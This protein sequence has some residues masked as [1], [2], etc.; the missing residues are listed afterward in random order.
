MMGVTVA[1]LALAACSSDGGADVEISMAMAPP[2]GTF[3]ASGDAVDD[4]MLCAT[5]QW[6]DG[7]TFDEDGDPISGEEWAQAFDSAMA[8]ETVVSGISVRT[9]TC[10]D[11][12]AVGSI[13]VADTVSIDFAQIDPQEWSEGDIASAEAGTWSVDG[14]TGDMSGMTGG[15]DLTWNLDGQQIVY[16]GQVSES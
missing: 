10:T 14:A 11:E 16:S 2:P 5:G 8:D 9:F 15:G 7:G 6:D 1:A 13:E 4:G 3:T 12:G